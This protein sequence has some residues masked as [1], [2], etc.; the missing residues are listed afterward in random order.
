GGTTNTTLTSIA[1]TYNNG[2][3]NTVSLT[4]SSSFGTNTLTRTN[5]IVVTNAFPVLVSNSFALVKETCTNGAIDPRVLV[6]MNF[7]LKNM[8]LGSSSTWVAALLASGGITPPSGPQ[9]YG[10]VTPNAR[11]VNAFTFT[12]PGGCGTTN[13]ATLQLQDGSLNL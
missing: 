2:G 5:Y 13:T 12:P 1:Y 3:T 8:G 4:V 6:T 7:G 9:N 10:T 11:A